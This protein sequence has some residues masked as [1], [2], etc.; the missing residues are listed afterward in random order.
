MEYL[1]LEPLKIQYEEI[2][3]EASSDEIKGGKIGN[4]AKQVTKAVENVKNAVEFIPE[5]DTRIYT[6]SRQRL[7]VSMMG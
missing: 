3:E 6:L 7:N 4:A 1:G 2:Q 5:D